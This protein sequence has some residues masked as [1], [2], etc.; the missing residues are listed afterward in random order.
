[1]AAF[2]AAEKQAQDP[3]VI[4]T[5]EGTESFVQY[6]IEGGVI[7]YDR[8]K[9]SLSQAEFDR[10]LATHAEVGIGPE[11]VTNTDVKTDKD[12]QMM[13][14]NKSFSYAEAEQAADLGLYILQECFGLKEGQG[15]VIEKGW[16]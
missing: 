6:W 9:G 15:L 4:V 13:V 8:P 2:K 1:M 14:L 7:E 10:V 11:E 12:F 5:I 16:E 3:F